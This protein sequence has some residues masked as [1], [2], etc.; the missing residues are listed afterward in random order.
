MTVIDRN[1]TFPSLI[2]EPTSLDVSPTVTVSIQEESGI[3]SML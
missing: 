2:P 3:S 1:E